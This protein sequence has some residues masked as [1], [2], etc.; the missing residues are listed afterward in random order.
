MVWRGF[1]QGLGW[2]VG[3]KKLWR[4]TSLW[5]CYTAFVFLL[6]ELTCMVSECGD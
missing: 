3:G 5:A 6:G 1:S 4:G 2:A